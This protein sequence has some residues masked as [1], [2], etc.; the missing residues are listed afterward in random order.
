[1]DDK[2]EGIGHWVPR[3]GIWSVILN[4]FHPLGD[5]IVSHD[6]VLESL[7]TWILDIIQL[8]VVEDQYKGVVVSDDH[9]MW[10]ACKKELALGDGP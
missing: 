9:E 5:E 10:E 3:Q 7:K 2:W 6:A 8:V 4:T 1:M